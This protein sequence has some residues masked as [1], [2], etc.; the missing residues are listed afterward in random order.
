MPTFKIHKKMETRRLHHHDLKRLARF[1]HGVPPSPYARDEEYVKS[2]KDEVKNLPRCL[3]QSRFS[4]SDTGQK[5][6]SAHKNLNHHLMNELWSWIRHE[7]NSGIG[8]FIYPIIMAGVLTTEQENKIRQLEP[9]LQV[10]RRDFS[11]EL[12]AAPGRHYIDRGLKWAYEEGQCPACILGR[13]GSEKRVLLALYAGM[14]GRFAT[15][16]LTREKIPFNELT[17]ATLDH[18][19]SKRIGFVRY[20]IK[21]TSRG[22]TLLHEATGL[23]IHLK[24]LYHWYSESQRT[25]RVS[26]Y[27]GRYSLDGT[28]ARP[29]LDSER[30]LRTSTDDSER[31]LRNS[32]DDPF[33]DPSAPERPPTVVG[34]GFIRDDTPRPSRRTTTSTQ[35]PDDTYPALRQQVTN[36]SY[37]YSYPYDPTAPHSDLDSINSTISPHDSISNR[38]SITQTSAFSHPSAQVSPLNIKR[39]PATTSYTQPHRISTLNEDSFSTISS[40]DGGA[41]T[42]HNPFET[43]EQRVWKWKERLQQ[44]FSTMKKGTGGSGKRSGI[45]EPRRE[46]MYH[47]FSADTS[48]DVDDDP[49]GDVV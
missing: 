22:E 35:R 4:V 7:L 39:K 5:L 21:A 26:L 33:R 15:R 46:S 49:F 25:E 37:R 24:R 27:T 38:A 31:T 34:W 23:G 13:L 36:Y 40:Y 8:R 47:G 42:A 11:L 41:P 32:T 12:S 30:T 10:Y 16:K 28:T 1:L 48:G 9:V 2:V 18:P 44:C 17:I 6:C 45:P 14:I 19:I 29:S 20:W 43:E 3:R